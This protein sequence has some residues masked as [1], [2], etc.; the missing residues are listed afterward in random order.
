MAQVSNGEEP[1]K[2]ESLTVPKIIEQLERAL[3]DI[4][5]NRPNDDELVF[6]KTENVPIN[7]KNSERPQFIGKEL[8]L[9]EMIGILNGKITELQKKYDKIKN[10]EEREEEFVSS[11]ANEITK[12]IQD[13]F[14]Y[15]K[16]AKA[17]HMDPN[18]A[19]EGVVGVAKRLQ[20][21][22]TVILDSNRITNNSLVLAKNNQ[23]INEIISECVEDVKNLK[24]MVPIRVGLDHDIEIPVDKMRLSQVIQTI[25]SNSIKYTE[26]GYIKVESFVAHQQNL[27]II[28]INDTGSNIPKDVLPR[29]FEKDDTESQI[30]DSKLSLYLCKGIIEAH[31]GKITAK[32]N[33]DAGCTFT[34]TLPIK[35]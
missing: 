22:S 13:I 26:S 1:K 27:V 19:L 25:L 7:S 3:I 34:I 33:A 14:D 2:L 5:Y 30:N 16:L 32:N 23:N 18:E 29:V 20:N 31:N 6:N 28:R 4:K 9:F 12:P 11:K 35:N 21:A 24:P 15:V 17:G 8:M 10:I